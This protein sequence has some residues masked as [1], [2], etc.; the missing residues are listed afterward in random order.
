MTITPVTYNREQLTQSKTV[1]NSRQQSGIS[2]N[3]HQRKYNR[4]S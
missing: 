4:Q 1:S 2:D 3:I